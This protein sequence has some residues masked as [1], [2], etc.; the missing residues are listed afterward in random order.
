[1]INKL[2]GNEVLNAQVQEQNFLKHF[3]S[4]LFQS[5]FQNVTHTRNPSLKMKSSRACDIPYSPPF[6]FGLSCLCVGRKE[7]LVQVFIDEKKQEKERERAK[8]S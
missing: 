1:M 2:N 5:I 3:S 7:K 6:S 8:K 4:I